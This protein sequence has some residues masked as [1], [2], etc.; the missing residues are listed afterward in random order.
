LLA[1][2]FPDEMRTS[3]IIQGIQ[4][5]LGTTLWEKIA[6]EFAL[7]SGFKVLNPR[8]LLLRPNPIPNEI[9]INNTNIQNEIENEIIFDLSYSI[10]INPSAFFFNTN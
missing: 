3:S 9:V 5:S 8:E 6:L 1:K 10:L 7:N 4:T 2:L